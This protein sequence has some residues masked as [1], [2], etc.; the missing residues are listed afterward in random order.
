MKHFFLILTLLFTTNV[1]FASSHDSQE[2][3][4][5][6]KAY[7][8][9]NKHKNHDDLLISL[10]PAPKQNNVSPDTIIEAVFSEEIDV[11]SIKKNSIFLKK[12]IWGKKKNRRNNKLQFI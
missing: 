4:N 3:K 9:H 2:F 11:K 8:Q 1:I 12:N 10:S 6:Y 5:I 7:K